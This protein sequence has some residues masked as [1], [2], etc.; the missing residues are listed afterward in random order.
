L[1]HNPQHTSGSTFVTREEYTKFW[2][3]HVLHDLFDDFRFP[4]P[5][6]D[7][8]VDSFAIDMFFMVIFLFGTIAMSTVAHIASLLSEMAQLGLV[9]PFLSSQSGPILVLL[10]LMRRCLP[11]LAGKFFI[12]SSPVTSVD[13][14]DGILSIS[15]QPLPVFLLLRLLLPTLMAIARAPSLKMRSANFYDHPKGITCWI[16]RTL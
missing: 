9:S 7:F 10:C 16:S 11:F 2:C 1:L 3:C 8:T 12:G 15:L 4:V 5:A 6:E 14:T 13:V